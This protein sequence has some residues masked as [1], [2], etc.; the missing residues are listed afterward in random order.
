MFYL[1]KTKQSHV[2][3]LGL[4]DHENDS[5]PDYGAIDDKEKEMVREMCNVRNF[6]F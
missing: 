4:N 6:Y 5:H 1:I 2:Q 3:V